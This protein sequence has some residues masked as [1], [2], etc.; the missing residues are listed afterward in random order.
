MSFILENKE[1]INELLFA[2]L[3]FE[4]KFSKVAQTVEGIDTTLQTIKDELLTTLGDPNAQEEAVGPIIGTDSENDVDLNTGNFSNL[5]NLIKFLTTSK[6]TV[7]GARITFLANEAPADRKGLA[8]RNIDNNTY[9][10]NTGLLTTY[11]QSLKD[12]ADRINNVVLSNKVNS[13][14]TEARNILKIEVKTTDKTP[15]AS[16]QTGKQTGEQV[17]EPSDVDISKIAA[18]TPLKNDYINISEIT[19][20]IHSFQENIINKSKDTTGRVAGLAASLVDINAAMSTLP[21][22]APNRSQF[23]ISMQTTPDDIKKLIQPPY[24]QTYGGLI[25]SLSVIVSGVRD[26]LRSFYEAYSNNKSINWDN[27][28][29]QAIGGSSSAQQLL[30]NLNRLASASI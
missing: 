19:K 9:Y 12:E 27:I 25:R 18:H 3:S 24:A 28:Q 7:D 22:V 13:L 30:D 21:T 17:G 23:V 15:G 20:F 26:M 8:V 6:I 2:G 10:I 29:R 16:Q 14:L 11:L 4:N 1:L 5:S